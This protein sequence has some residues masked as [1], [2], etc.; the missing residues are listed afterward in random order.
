[1]LALFNIR[2]STVK[3]M[4]DKVFKSING[5][6]DPKYVDTTP[7][8]KQENSPDDLIQKVKKT[9]LESGMFEHA[10]NYEKIPI[11]KTIPSMSK[12]FSDLNKDDEY[13]Q[14]FLENLKFLAENEVYRV[15][16]K[17]YFDYL[18]FSSVNQPFNSLVKTNPRSLE[19][20][21][22]YLNFV[23]EK[24]S[25]SEIVS[26][27][28]FINEEREK[29]S[30]V[31]LKKPISE[32]MKLRNWIFFEKIKK[33]SKRRFVMYFNDWTL[34]NSQIIEY[35]VKAIFKLFWQLD[36]LI[37]GAEE[38]AIEEL[39]KANNTIG[40]MIQYFD[41]DGKLTNLA[42]LRIYRN[43]TFH[44]KVD[45]IY[46]QRENERKLVFEDNYGKIEVDIEGFV[47]D[48]K[49][50][51]IFIATI[52][53]L[54]ANTLYKADNDGQNVFQVNYEYAKTNGMRKFWTWQTKE[55]NTNRYLKYLQ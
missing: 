47:S 14:H 3:V 7:I 32:L 23:E 41:S 49:K 34:K 18:L 33:S 1:M 20:F 24:I 51:T 38:G 54:V 6:F 29:M 36:L 37:R 4:F 27:F 13:I 15:K 53:Y 44:P 11:S 39:L 42:R 50:I 43:G 2:I 28:N 55:K 25:V 35:N 9:I 22:K 16:K 8:P 17:A 46:N 21:A 45:F 12:L 48:F 31:A 52:N 5:F 19:F 40:K 26:S 30:E 10:K